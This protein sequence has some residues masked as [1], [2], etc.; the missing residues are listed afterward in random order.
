[1]KYFVTLSGESREVELSAEGVSLDGERHSAEVA[2]VPGTTLRHLRLEDRGFT[3][4]ARRSDE[5]WVFRVA[6][7]SVRVEV[8]DERTRAIRQLAGRG[9][10]GKGERELRAPMPGRVVRLL[11][12]PGQAVE[13]GDGLVVMEAMKMEN[14]LSARGA[15]TV[16]ELRVEE[17]QTVDQG[18]VL[19]VLER[20]GES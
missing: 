4:T 11:V 18:A 13:A 1:M 3:M 20:G 17:G 2:T 9:E 7:R 6:G 8:E 16:E 14:E 15:G 19:I 10:E 5:G 12:E